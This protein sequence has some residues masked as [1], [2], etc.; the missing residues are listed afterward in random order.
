[1]NDLPNV[2]PNS[3]IQMYADD[4]VVFVDANS[5]DQAAVQL[6]NSMLK[7]TEWLKHNNYS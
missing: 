5:A 1:M 7:I 4:A 6:T 2:C 3:N